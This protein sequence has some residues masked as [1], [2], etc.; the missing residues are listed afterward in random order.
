MSHEK[1]VWP[2]GIPQVGQ[3]AALARQVSARDIELFTAKSGD[4][5]PPSRLPN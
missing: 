4:H 3:K 1:E 2:S 5:N